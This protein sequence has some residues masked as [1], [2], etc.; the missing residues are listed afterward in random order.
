M[1]NFS[2]EL[3][4]NCLIIRFAEPMKILSWAPFNGGLTQSD[5]I[6]NWQND[7][8]GSGDLQTLFKEKVRQV[9]IPPHS[10]G[11][12]TA[13]E[14]KNFKEAESNRGPL[15]VHSIVTVGLDN[16][17]TVGDRA[18]VEP[19]EG[20]KHSGTINLTVI[21]NALPD[22]QGQAEAV[23]VATMAKTKALMD[24]GVLSKKSGNPA[25][26]TGTDCI[27]IAASGEIK[28]NYCGMHTSLGQLIG[29]TV[30]QSI[31]Q[32]ISISL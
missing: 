14:I 8:F 10:V 28:E 2:L 26:G 17:R 30:Y 25:T 11:M 21:C 4:D 18:D 1:N 24:A 12:I 7:K 9:E 15:K 5:C 16:T 32:G 13:A 29:E 23:Q 31:S 6:F 27:V 22:L 20:C 19:G 3:R